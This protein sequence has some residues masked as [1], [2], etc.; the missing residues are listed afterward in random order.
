MVIFIGILI[1]WVL[2]IPG[3]LLLFKY[4]WLKH[5]T[6]KYLLASIFWPLYLVIMGVGIILVL[7]CIDT[8]NDKIDD[9]INYDA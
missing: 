8:I 6:D 5:D 2:G 3:T 1:L 4:T 9:W 7:D